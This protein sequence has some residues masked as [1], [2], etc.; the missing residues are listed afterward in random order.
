MGSWCWSIQIWMVWTLLL[1]APTLR[2]TPQLLPPLGVSPPSPPLPLVTTLMH[3]TYHIRILRPSKRLPF[4]SLKVD[5]SAPWRK[6]INTHASLLPNPPLLHCH[7]SQLTS[8]HFN[9]VTLSTQIIDLISHFI[10]SA[11]I[12]VPPSYAL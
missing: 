11:H 5:W 10:L 3:E 2:R 6:D 12:F 7:H 4:G 8:L 9:T 1:E